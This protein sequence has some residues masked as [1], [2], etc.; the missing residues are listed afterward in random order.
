MAGSG[1]AREE[2]QARDVRRRLDGEARQ[3][4]DLLYNLAKTARSFGFYS[5]TNQAIAR[6]LEELFTGFTTYL[7]EH[8]VLRLGV[9]ADRFHFGEHEVYHD[10]DREHG[11]PFRLFRDGIRGVVFK[12]G[13][14]R[15]ELDHLLDVLARRGSTGR[16]AEEED[17][18]TMLWKLSFEHLTYQAV[19]GFTHDLHAGAGDEGGQG[20][21]TGEAIPRMMER[22]SGARATF[23]RPS[24]APATPSGRGSATGGGAAQ[25]GTHELGDRSTGRV[26]RSFVDRTAGDDPGGELGGDLAAAGGALA[27]LPEVEAPRFKAGLYQGARDYPLRL[28]GGLVEFEY[29]GVTEVEREALL[30]EL[31][32]DEERGLI[33]LLDYCFELCLSEPRYFK[34]E[35]FEPIIAPVRRHLVRAR[36]LGT[37]DVV[38]RY[39]R[40]I[41]AGG[42]YP[43]HLTEAARRMLT[44]CASSEALA[45]L[46]ASVTGDPDAEDMAWD[47]LQQLLP[48]LEPDEMLTLLGHGMSQRLAQILAA[49]LIRRTG[50]SL[51]LYEQA[52]A[53]GDLPR[54]LAALR[55]LATLRSE[56]AVLMIE[57]R[58]AAPEPAIRRAAARILG[59]VP[60]SPT[61]G[62]ALGRGLRD[63]DPA[64][65]D[66]AIAAIYRQGLPE[67]ASTLFHWFEE[68]GFRA[69]DADERVAVVRLL[70]ELDA[71]YAVR[72]LSDK[73]NLGLRAKMGGIAGAAEIGEWN[74][75]A[76]EGLAAAGTNSALAR[77][78]EV[79]TQGNQELKEL[80]TRRLI[81]AAR[82]AQT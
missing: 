44:D 69:L 23:K 35:A 3:V 2:F 20:G 15:Q 73:L 72:S 31:Q 1:D 36:Q 46:V 33:H 60:G 17:V 19:E 62:R 76:V 53:G 6:F 41:S 70:A 74:R 65:R 71:E 8:E 68:S 54:A 38:L 51:S 55:C 75:V 30:A 16:D 7:D 47:V 81:E 48:S 28:R 78:S 24:D 25:E 66:E 11:L 27:A 42:I 5:R 67:L 14:E 26:A 79:R 10:P 56:E 82:K 61:L 63:E 77:L 37:Y 80:V 64:V 57:G 49:T 12:Q 34:P 39:L 9:G 59:R 29:Q 22:I 52:L 43:E 45:G 58:V 40:R 32:E 21:D 13:L 50:S 4:A 18:V